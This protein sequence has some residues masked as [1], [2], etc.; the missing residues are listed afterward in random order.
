MGDDATPGCVFVREV[1]R[2]LAGDCRLLA[3]TGRGGVATVAALGAAGG[4]TGA[5][6]GGGFTSVG[7]GGAAGLLLEGCGF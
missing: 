1:T 3:A 5:C 2:S 7:V 6:I 4:A